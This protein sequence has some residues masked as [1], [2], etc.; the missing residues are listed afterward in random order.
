MEHR[1]TSR[2]RVVGVD[3]KGPLPPSGTD[4]TAAETS[5]GTLG[6]VSGT[7]GL[8]LLRLDRAEEAKAT[9]QPLRAGDVTIAFSIPTWARFK[10]PTPIAP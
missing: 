2:K 10:S 3:G 4:I 1:G 6:S 9:G 8:A 5:I 7:S